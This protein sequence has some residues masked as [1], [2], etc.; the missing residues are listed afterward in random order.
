MKSMMPQGGAVSREGFGL[1]AGKNGVNECCDC[2]RA[3][4]EGA[5]ILQVEE[6]EEQ[7]ERLQPI[8]DDEH[9]WSS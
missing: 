8:T 4:R 7:L 9:D 1:C 2:C 6:G 3:G 5:V